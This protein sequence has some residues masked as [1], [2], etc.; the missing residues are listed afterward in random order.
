MLKNIKLR[1]HVSDAY[2]T[3]KVNDTTH[4]HSTIFSTHD[5]PSCEEP[6]IQKWYLQCTCEKRENSHETVLVSYETSLVSRE[7]GRFSQYE[8]RFSQGGG[9]LHLSGTIQPILLYVMYWVIPDYS[10]ISNTLIPW[11][12]ICNSEGKGGSLNWK[13]KGN[14][15]LKIGILSA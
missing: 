12:P 6:L 2:F 9:N 11:A 14:G 15:V 3:E 1:S 13:S 10:C 4:V 5:N 8:S 7:T